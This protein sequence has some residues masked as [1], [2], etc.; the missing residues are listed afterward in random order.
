M[1]LSILDL[2]HTPLANS[3]LA[4]AD[5]AK[6]EPT[7][8]LELAFCESC[9]LVQITETVP[10]EQLFSDYLYFSS[11]SDTMLAHARAIVER[12]I[13]ERSLG[14]ESLVVEIASN[15]GYLLQYYRDRGVPVLG[16]EPARN[17][18][19][20]AEERGIRTRNTFFGAEE[21]KRL[22]AEGVHAHVIHANN[23]FAHVADT[24]GFV[25]GLG[26]ILAPRG[27][28]IVEV[29]YVRDMIEGCEF[30]TIYH[31]H[32]CY[33]SLSALDCLFQRHGL[34]IIDAERIT[35]HGGSL[36]VF[37]AHAGSG[38]AVSARVEKLLNEER[39]AGLRHLSYYEDFARRVR[40]LRVELTTLLAGLRAKG[41]RVAAYGAAAKGATLLNYCGI[42]TETLEFVVDRS[43]YKQG[44]VMPGVHV[45][46]HAPSY[47]LERMPEYV[48]LLSWNF[49]AEIM[50]QQA[51]YRARGGQ[52]IVPVPTPIIV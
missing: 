49:A 11:F 42:G 12:V 3:L 31:E 9:A 2:G 40:L 38:Q 19:K 48:L 32:L 51:D 24:N 8:P 17:I 33:F 43:T 25:E 5:L 20:V 13:V 35:I 21:A 34:A 16:I 1:R 28:A 26:R 37:V 36:R 39:D 10:P 52:F 45:P 50:E 29:P 14:P 6:P 47:L 4:A 22:A 23:V 41:K 46:I 30:D 18:A 27:V 44:R 15:D 7:Y